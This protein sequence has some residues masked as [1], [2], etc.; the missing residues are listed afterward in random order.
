VP[1]ERTRWT[2]ERLDD[3]GERVNR[4]YDELVAKIDRL[5]DSVDRLRG[6][7]YTTRLTVAGIWIGLAAIFI[8]IALRT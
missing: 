1:L 4:Q 3:L 7:F 5:Q 8:E 2:D 6:E